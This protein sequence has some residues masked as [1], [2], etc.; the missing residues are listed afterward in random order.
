MAEDRGPTGGLSPYLTIKGGR[1]A[2]AATFYGR[3]FGAETAFQA[4]SQD[5]P[6]L[7]HCH[8]RVNGASLLMS[9]DFPEWSGGRESP[10]PGGYTLHLQVD[11]VDAWFARALGA[12]C[13]ETMK[14]ETQFWG[15]R[16]GKVRDPFGVN[17]SIASTPQ[18]T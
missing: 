16:Y 8:V 13:V 1:C 18:A 10:D 5:G 17:W 11:D 6:K 9:D 2:E 15:D 3:A 4:Q 12:G 14:L 7:M